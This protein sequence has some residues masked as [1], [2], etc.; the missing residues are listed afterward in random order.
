MNPPHPSRRTTSFGWLEVLEE[1][2]G[3]TALERLRF[4]CNGRS[5]VHDRWEYVRV[6]SGTGVIVAGDKRIAVETGDSVDIPPHTAHWMETESGMDL[7]LM[8]GPKAK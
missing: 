7:V 4:D 1:I 8:Y 5:H 2:E 6:T 3:E